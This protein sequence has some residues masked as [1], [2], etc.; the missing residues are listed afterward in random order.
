[1]TF[2][3]SVFECYFL[4]SLDSIIGMNKNNLGREAGFEGRKVT[5]LFFFVTLRKKL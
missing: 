2:N 3:L 5:V 4:S 1:M